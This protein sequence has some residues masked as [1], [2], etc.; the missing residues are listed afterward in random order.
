ML[1]GRIDVIQPTIIHLITYLLSLPDKKPTAAV[2]KL[3][4][5][6]GL[7]RNHHQTLS[8]DAAHASYQK[9]FNKVLSFVVM[10][11][12]EDLMNMSVCMCVKQQTDDLY[13]I[14]CN[15]IYIVVISYG[16]NNNVAVRIVA[17]W[18]LNV[19]TSS[20]LDRHGEFVFTICHVRRD[21]PHSNS[22]VRSSIPWVR[23]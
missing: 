4:K 17:G 22:P 19:F 21:P 18:N 16:R 23:E 9:R 13:I 6:T 11:S 8:R 3:D 5:T 12:S 7:D 1:G 20:W 2:V 14:I 10:G 15:C